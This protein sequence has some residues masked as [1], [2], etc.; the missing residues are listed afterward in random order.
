[1]LAK[2]ELRPDSPLSYT[3]EE[4][5]I[6]SG[7]TSPAE[8][9]VDTSTQTME[10]K[11]NAPSPKNLVVEIDNP[12][13]QPIRHK[14]VSNKRKQIAAQVPKARNNNFT[15]VYFNPNRKPIANIANQSQQIHAIPQS[16]STPILHQQYRSNPCLHSSNPY[17]NNYK[18]MHHPC[19]YPPASTTTTT[20]AR[21][22]N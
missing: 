15:E 7:Q 8:T 9:I 21:T 3:V 2:S 19:R 11:D 22:T 4:A 13:D 12:E 16:Q 18:R 14:T 20:H 6:S 17:L 5:E 1:M 10:T